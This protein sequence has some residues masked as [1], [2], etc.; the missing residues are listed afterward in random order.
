MNTS[1]L[2]RIPLLALR[3]LEAAV[4]L[5]SFETAARELNVSA[6]AVSQQI[7][8]IERSI[9]FSLFERLGNRT[10][11][12][13]RG[14]ELGRVLTQAFDAIAIGVEEAASSGMS[15]GVK[16][17][18]Y[19]TLANRWLIP[20]LEDFSRQY[21]EVSV[22]FE[23]GSGDVD[24]SHTDADMAICFN[25]ASSRRVLRQELFSSRLTPV[26]TP[27]V[28]LENA[29]DLA[30]VPRISSR[31]RMSDWPTWLSASGFKQER[32]TRLLLFSNS[33]LAYEAALAGMGMVVAQIELVIN[34]LQSGRLVQPFAT[35]IRSQ[36]SVALLEP[37]IRPRNPAATAFRQWV[38]QEVKALTHR[39]DLFLA[40]RQRGEMS[41]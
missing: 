1:I 11:P 40:Q 31:N 6:S 16:I 38:V 22:E 7:H 19:Q 25:A 28:A 36:Q 24:F 32:Q 33:T 21:P 14:L 29:T 23:T 10:V 5:G 4:R 27:R 13:R 34:D 8:R 41:L 9:G 20:N 18:V 37:E 30:S 12:T 26:C 3:H 39:T 17:R 15:H 35:C 2:S